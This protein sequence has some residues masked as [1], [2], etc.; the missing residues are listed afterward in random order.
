MH[1]GE[2]KQRQGYSASNALLVAGAFFIF[3]AFLFKVAAFPFH[4]WVIDVYDGA[5]APVTGFMATALKTAVF[6]VFANFLARYSDELPDI[7][8]NFVN[9][10]S[11]NR[12]FLN[13]EYIMDHEFCVLHYYFYENNYSNL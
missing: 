1:S 6:V 3:V 12:G 9:N 7:T 13:F 10:S 4:A 5:A 11:T 2:T 8:V